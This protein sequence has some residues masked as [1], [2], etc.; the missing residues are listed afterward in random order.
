VPLDLDLTFG[1]GEAVLDMR[2]VDARNLIVNIGTGTLNLDLTGARK[3]SL[4]VTIKGGIGS[5]NVEL[6]KDVGVSVHASGGIGAVI[7]H[8]LTDRGHDYTNAAFGNTP[9][10]IYITIE[11]GIGKIELNAQP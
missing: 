7:T 1:A 4:N 8:G 6:P 11:G 2:G 3:N 10:T 5:A 9:A